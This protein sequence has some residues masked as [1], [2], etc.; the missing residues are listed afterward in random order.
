MGSFDPYCLEAEAIMRR[1]IEDFCF[2][3]LKFEMSSYGGFMGFHP[4]FKVDGKQMIPVWQYEVAPVVKTR[5]W[6]I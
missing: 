4:E 2:K 6:Q 1:L 3:G 5:K